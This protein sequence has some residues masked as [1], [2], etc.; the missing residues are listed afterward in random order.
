MKRVFLYLMVVSFWVN[1]SA[2]NQAQWTFTTNRINDSI[3][4]LLLKCSLDKGWHIYSQHTK[5]TE[6]PIVFS[7]DKSNNYQRIGGVKEPASKSHYDKFAKDTTRFFE[8]NIVFRQRVKVLSNKDFKINGSVDFQLCENGSCIPPTLLDFSFDVKGNPN[9]S[10]E[11]EVEKEELLAE[12]TP[13]TEQNSEVTSLSNTENSTT[14]Q[15]EKSIGDT[16]D[17]ANKSLL[18]VFL[19]SFGVGLI[20]LL[21]PCVFPMIPMTISFFLHGKKTNRQGRKQAYFFGLSIVLIF[22]VLGLLLTLIFG[23]DAMYIISTHWIPNVLFFVIF[24]IF[25]LSFFGLFEITMPSKWVNKSDKESEKGGF[26]GA[27]FIALTTVLVSF[28]CTGPI[29]GAALVEMASG[30]SNSFIFFVSMLGFAIG[31][32]LPFT[33]LA[34]FPSFLK[35]MKSGSWLNS[36][37]IVFGFL[38]IALGLKFLMVADQACNW[39]I[40]PRTTYL[41]IWIVIFFM[42][43]FYL[44][45]KLKFK[46]DSELKHITVPRLF[47]SIVSFSFAIYMIPGL[48]GAPLSTISGYL[49]PVSSQ[50]Y[51]I[52]KIIVE[53]K[54][55][56]SANA[57]DFPINRK[58]ADK[59]DEH[60][61][62]GFRAFFDLEE[63]KQYAKKV[64]KPLF[65]DFTGKSCAN[66][67]EMETAV[68]SVPAVKK[69]IQED[70]ILV[71]LYCDENTIE[72]PKEEWQE[73]N[74]KTIKT[75]GRRNHNYQIEKF[76]ANAQPLYV[77][78]DGEGNLLTDKPQP[79]DKSVNNF[80][81]FLTSGLDKYNSTKQ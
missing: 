76:H 72:L 52:E 22:A 39:G 60:V 32:A 73:M 53:N 54:G 71:S 74:G 10:N 41:C 17:L 40:L 8:G 16:Q 69:M 80:I 68:W 20:T 37:K 26:L 23:K 24:M 67:R 58:Y 9:I 36:V 35:N 45:G 13:T 27:F 6:Q 57:D 66:C 19:I 3:S 61:P 31:F 65:L 43:G 75:L 55:T 11:K 1:V 46:G 47:L 33:L 77:L 48:W 56:G 7:F 38:E 14:T 29:L 64:G 25:A 78:M 4:E 44:L 28:S 34:M 21:T 50:E 18:M 2:Q 62:V 42:I 70:Y 63:A 30:S 81:N 51:N 49:P 12:S 59:L 15:I 5:G 79:Y